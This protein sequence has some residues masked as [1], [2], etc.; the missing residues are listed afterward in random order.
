[1]YFTPPTLVPLVTTIAYMFL[2]G[3]LV[4]GAP[5]SRLRSALLVYVAL[6]GLWSFGSFMTHLDP[7]FLSPTTWLRVG[8]TL[9]TTSAWALLR[10]TYIFL[11]KHPPLWTWLYM[12]VGISMGLLQLVGLGIQ[13][14]TNVQGVLETT[15]HPIAWSLMLVSLTGYLFALVALSRTYQ[16][17]RDVEFRN[18]I[19]YPAIGIGLIVLGVLTNFTPLGDYASDVAAGFLNALLLAYAV[20]RYRLLNVQLALPKMLAVVLAAFSVLNGYTLGVLAVDSWTGHSRD[21]DFLIALSM[22][23]L[24]LGVLFLPL[25]QLIHRLL[26]S[27]ALFPSRTTQEELMGFGLELNK[28]LDLS[29]LKEALRYA[30]GSLYEATYT[31]LLIKGAGQTQM[32]PIEEQ[33]TPPENGLL[34]PVEESGAL[35][36]IMKGVEGPISGT[37]ILEH[38]MAYGLRETER[39]LLGQL[40]ANR[41]VAPLMSRGELIGLLAV[42]RQRSGL[43][44]SAEEQ[45]SI[46]I[47]ANHA[48]SAVQNARLY[49]YLLKANASMVEAERAKHQAQSTQALAEVAAGM[50]HDFNNLLTP[51]IG[52]ADL[53]L[54]KAQG[55]PV[56]EDLKLI[57]RAAGDAAKLSNRL[58]LLSRGTQSSVSQPIRLDDVIRDAAEFVRPRIMELR[59]VDQ[60]HI[61]LNEDLKATSLVGGDSVELREVLVN[62]LLNS[63]DAMPM[64]GVISL[65]TTDEAREHAVRLEVHDAGTG[66]APE[67]KERAFEPFFTTKQKGTGLGLPLSKA[68]VERMGGTIDLSTGLGGGMTVTVRLPAVPAEKVQASS[69]PPFVATQERGKGVILVVDDDPSV[70]KLVADH[71]QAYGYHVHTATR[72]IQALKLLRE[73][74]LDAAIIDLAMPD[75]SGFE[76]AAKIKE[77]SP[78]TPV[79]LITGWSLAMDEEDLARAGIDRVLYK[80]F[81]S[82]QIAEALQQLIGQ[83]NV[84]V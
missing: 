29:E 68:I 41:V 76:L 1:M 3:V 33:A 31:K 17:S 83:R 6:L 57:L 24:A 49:Q 65:T 2:S 18:R 80:P 60:I 45:R 8:I 13:E 67:V 84:T 54:A 36:T 73:I 75:L 43:S 20:F 30:L 19:L 38:S 63:I 56:E 42:G 74:R 58:M 14:V 77:I 4:L 53:G 26:L 48:A 79:C 21:V 9:G 28:T 40:A 15:A 44:Y 50:A 23:A 70:V 39:R 51:I 64:G 55:S 71:I 34:G 78:T 66:M 11:G 35:A 82:E 37:E 32:L 10:Y 16:R 7:P 47:L 27:T 59:G 46:G 72:G 22:L 81:R 52:F 62:L 5:N 69:E 61:T 12:V 25:V